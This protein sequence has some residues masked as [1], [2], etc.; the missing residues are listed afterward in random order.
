[1]Q[2]KSGFAFVPLQSAVEGAP[3]PVDPVPPYGY[4]SLLPGHWAGTGFN[5]ITRP[6]FDPSNPSQNTFLELNLTNET[7]DF[8]LIEG[9][10]PNRG[11]HQGDIDMYGLTYLQQVSDANL[12]T[13]G[14]IV[15]LHAEPGVW[16]NVP[17]TTAP[18]EPPTVVRMASIPH[19]TAIIAQGTA[20]EQQ[21]VPDFGEPAAPYPNGFNPKTGSVFIIPEAEDITVPSPYRSSGQQV[22]GITQ[23]MLDKPVETLLKS[24]LAQQTILSTV[25]L[26]V[27]TEPG[28]PTDPTV[29][30][31]GG[32]ANTAF[33]AGAADG[34]P[35]ALAAKV[36]STFWIETV[37]G[38]NGQPD[39]LQLQ[40]RQTVFLE[41]DGFFWPHVSVATLTRQG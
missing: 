27:S 22:Q 23:A 31:G 36:D 39:F 3:P 6:F 25:T 30:C 21:G 12:S 17:A 18:A 8:A 7:I 4:L 16:A 14:N 5:M 33:L 40:Y 41:F 20:V 29:T 1:M 9:A 19:G 35:N 28:D 15:G 11:R 37:Q 32:T 38:M 13:P 2:L 10:I 24:V 26:A 34:S